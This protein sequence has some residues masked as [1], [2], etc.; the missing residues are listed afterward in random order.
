MQ[1]KISN[2]YMNIL[3]NKVEKDIYH[4]IIKLKSNKM[5]QNIYPI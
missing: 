3:I 4:I 2:K 1:N 5:I